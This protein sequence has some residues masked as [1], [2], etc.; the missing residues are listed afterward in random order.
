MTSPASA[1]PVGHKFS[2]F[3]GKRRPRPGK[4]GPLQGPRATLVT[5]APA[6]PPPL[7]RAGPALA[8]PR[9]AIPPPRNPQ[10]QDQGAEPGFPSATPLRNLS[11]GSPRPKCPRQAPN[12][13]WHSRGPVRGLEARPTPTHDL[14]IGW[15]RP[16][17]S[18]PQRRAV[19][20]MV[21]GVGA[22]GSHALGKHTLH[23]SCRVST[24]A[25]SPGCNCELT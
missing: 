24:E 10:A 13:C 11:R 19:Y 15:A 8:P 6:R 7:P 5:P 14:S 12:A 2:S 25:A 3:P 21:L 22:R 23:T 9:P 17:E 4:G 18:H 20:R 16:L 1:S